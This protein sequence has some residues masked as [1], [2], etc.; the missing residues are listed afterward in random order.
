MRV[1]RGWRWMK[2]VHRKVEEA[3]IPAAYV[4]RIIVSIWAV[5]VESNSEVGSWMVGI[6]GKAL[7]RR[8]MNW[9]VWLCSMCCTREWNW[10][11]QIWSGLYFSSHLKRS[12]FS[13]RDWTSDGVS[14]WK[15]VKKE[16]G[17]TGRSVLWGGRRWKWWSLKHKIARW[18]VRGNFIFNKSREACSLRN[19]CGTKYL[20]LTLYVWT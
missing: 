5:I 7:S 19:G 20:E 6:D 2:V 11:L 10:A 17:F 13:L 1:A 14:L 15:V 8:I 4:L 16:D 18:R 3:L 12:P 9:S